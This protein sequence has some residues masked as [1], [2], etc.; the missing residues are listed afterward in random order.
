MAIEP[1]KASKSLSRVGGMAAATSGRHGLAG[2]GEEGA[3]A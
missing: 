3:C 1:G 2:S